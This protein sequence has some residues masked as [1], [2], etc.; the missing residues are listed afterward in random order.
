MS[1]KMNERTLSNVGNYGN[2]DCMGSFRNKSKFRNMGNISKRKDKWYLCYVSDADNVSNNNESI[3]K[4][5]FFLVIMTIKLIRVTPVICAISVMW[6][7]SVTKVNL[8]MRE[9]SVT[10]EVIRQKK[11]NA[12]VKEWKY[13]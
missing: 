4:N 11:E 9:I 1:T 8:V 2:L 7:M 10:R 6:A 3:F 13:R 5:R 12:F